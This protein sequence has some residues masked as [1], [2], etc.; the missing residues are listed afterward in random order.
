M[1]NNNPEL[2][3][4][5][6][7][8]NDFIEKKRS[9][10]SQDEINQMF[11]CIK[12]WEKTWKNPELVSKFYEEY[13]KVE[14][15]Y[16]TWKK[17]LAGDT[18]VEQT[19]LSIDKFSVEWLLV[20]IDNQKE[21]IDSLLIDDNYIDHDELNR[22]DYGKLKKVLSISNDSE[23]QKD[24][25]F[26]Q[27]RENLM[28]SLNRLIKKYNT[29]LSQ[30]STFWK[31]E[32]LEWFIVDM[33]K[34][35]N[36]E[37]L[38]WISF[39]ESLK[40]KDL[41]ERLSIYNSLKW[42]QE[43]KKLVVW[44][45]IEDSINKKNYH[46]TY[47]INWKIIVENNKF[48]D[49]SGSDPE[50]KKIITTIS[51]E[52]LKLFVL[53]DVINGSWYEWGETNYKNIINT[54]FRKYNINYAEWWA[55]V[56]EDIKTNKN[57]IIWLINEKISSS[58]DSKT[59]KDLNFVLD[60]INNQTWYTNDSIEQAL[61]LSV[62]EKSKY[63]INTNEWREN[64]KKAVSKWN[65]INTIIN[66]IMSS[67]WGLVWVTLIIWWIISLFV[68]WKWRKGA[69][70]MFWLW[71]FAPAIEELLHKYWAWD[72]TKWLW[73]TSWGWVIQEAIWYFQW[74]D[75]NIKW[76]PDKFQ[77]K[78]K[79]MYKQ[80]L[81]SP[82]KI[83]NQDFA[84]IF[85][86]LASKESVN[87]LD[88]WV[89]KRWLKEWKTPEQ[90]LWIWNVPKKYN[91]WILTSE[92]ETII[93]NRNIPSSSVKTFLELLIASKEDKD[94]KVADLFVSWKSEVDTYMYRESNFNKKATKIIWGLP[95]WT[96][97]RTNLENIVWRT[98]KILSIEVLE[99]MQS[100]VSRTSK[101]EQLNWI[102]WELNSL[103]SEYNQGTP[104]YKVIEEIIQ[105]YNDINNRIE[106]ELESEELLNDIQKKG[107]V[108]F[109]WAKDSMKNF[110]N[111]VIE[112]IAWMAV[113]FWVTTDHIPNKFWTIN[114]S[115][116]DNLIKKS[117]DYIKTIDTKA[118]SKEEKNELK[119]KF[120]DI[121]IAMKE[122]KWMIL[123]KDPAKEIEALK[124]FWE[125]IEANPEKYLEDLNSMEVSMSE[126]KNTFDNY[127]DAAKALIINFGNIK[128]IKEIA[129]VPWSSQVKTKA[130]ELLSYYD[131]NFK[132]NILGI[133]KKITGK[134]DVINNEINNINTSDEDSIKKLNDLRKEY[135]E[136]RKSV[137]DTGYISNKL[138]ENDLKDKTLIVT[139]K[140]YIKELDWIDLP[141]LDWKNLDKKL[142]EKD[143]KLK[144]KID[145]LE[146]KYDVIVRFPS[147]IYNTQV[148]EKYIEDIKWKKQV[149][150]EFSDINKDIKLKEIEKQNF[151]VMNKFK[152]EI[153]K[154]DV[155]KSW[156]IDKVE[157]LKLHYDLFVEKLWNWWDKLFD[158]LY[159]KKIQEYAEKMFRETA[160]KMTFEQATDE[161]AES[162]KLFLKKY[163]K[164]TWLQDK[165]WSII[166]H[167]E[168]T[169]N[170]ILEEIKDFENEKDLW[171]DTST[172]N[173]TEN[174]KK[175]N[176]RYTKI[177]E[178][179]NKDIESTIIDTMWLFKWNISTN[180]L[181]K[182]EKYL[183][184]SK[185]YFKEKYEKVKDLAN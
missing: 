149:V 56:Y 65:W 7:L 3:E 71:I 26:I 126:L 171:D 28:L 128:I 90:I 156:D 66:D 75:V 175:N 101:K 24:Q 142:K 138:I 89:I 93:D 83:D 5:E 177:F 84:Q 50:I 60:Y 6:A 68:W 63:N 76:L 122:N 33:Q 167:P 52:E 44:N 17:D 73:N 2:N 120:Q 174:I 30:D 115:D 82:N 144:W 182:F 173:D 57:I 81:N 55:V 180:I 146:K 96:E 95:L 91:S 20:D 135:E 54:L 40:T 110:W 176:P 151:N 19:R 118:I 145:I 124:V 119:K 12:E 158:G 27:K 47:W 59:K 36:Y 94:T 184:V 111:A 109:Y 125:L 131:N 116:L 123:K 157:K 166:N 78:Y 105:L 169:I 14:Q 37:V 42:D 164:Y 98:N 43:K 88:I 51:N 152:D 112:W 147:D 67:N 99:N 23:L 150:K 136:I 160:W 139:L 32:K 53:K 10:F 181:V 133:E 130:E 129:K 85:S 114:I 134:L 121:I 170:E 46:L 74:V 172:P 159:W 185:E 102:I 15:K 16:N 163:R 61:E 64:I 92:N 108:R 104:E 69:M 11:E 100:A 179:L 62:L 18:I 77:S 45:I 8:V 58:Q 143:W 155:N 161:A 168:K 31:N 39:T 35:I 106:V 79:S 153:K 72:L 21:I 141:W 38:S 87:N 97:L 127:W 4:K 154:L 148:I 113:Y 48:E 165:I 29:R 117:E 183:Q 22:V 140:K 178:T 103:K 137:K 9:D 1:G 80:N 34:I 49:I 13:K 132:K 107:W 41:D 25:K 162:I 86:Q 70:W